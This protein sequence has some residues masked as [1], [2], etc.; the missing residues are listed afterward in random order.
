MKKTTVSIKGVTFTPCNLSPVYNWKSDIFQLYSRPS[1]TKIAIF[2]DRS[3]KL[4]GIYS[5]TGNCNFF[6]IYGYIFD[7]AWKKHNVKITPSYN[8]ILD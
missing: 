4:D 1:A 2:K 8:Y 5:L 6:S 7:D 3:Q